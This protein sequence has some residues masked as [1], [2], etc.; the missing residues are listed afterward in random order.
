M[1]KVI[2]FMHMSLDGFI[3]RPNG[4]MDWAT[5][6]DDAMGRYLI[7]DLLSTV[8]TMI[9]GRVLY[10]GFEKAWPAQAK[11]PSNPT[12][13]IEF[14]HWVEDTPKIVFSKTLD[15]VDWKSSTIVKVKDDGDIA[16]EISKLKE[17]PGKD[18]VLFGG[19]RFSQTCVKLGL[20]DEFRLKV[21]PVVLGIG[22][23]LFQNFQERV[24]L[25][26]THSK[27]FDSGVV[28]LYY[29]ILRK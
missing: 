6:N 9:L 4:E 29:Q 1:G 10:Q 11:N 22:K 23:P 17:Q 28:G 13:L 24:N 27:S 3:A 26:L 21:E 15:K 8:D 14:A 20:V 25:K 18:M 7:P 2:L 5:M 12:D 16:K 19:A